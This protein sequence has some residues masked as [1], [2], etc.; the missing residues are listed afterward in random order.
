M[1]TILRLAAVLTC[2]ILSIR[3]SHASADPMGTDFVP[4]EFDSVSASRVE[5]DALV[6][7]ARADGQSDTAMFLLKANIPCYAT[8]AFVN[9]RPG[10]AGAVGLGV[11][12]AYE[13]KPGSVRCQAFRELAFSTSMSADQS[14]KV[15]L[16]NAAPGVMIETTP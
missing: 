12:Y 10:T 7:G 15:Y 14:V 1:K 2:S 9:L 3:P 8:S 16:I 6:T 13:I 11:R 4:H 5:A